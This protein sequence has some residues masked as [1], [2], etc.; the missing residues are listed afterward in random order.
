MK[1][2]LIF[3]TAL[4]ALIM[5]TRPALALGDREAAILG[6]V[7]GGA[8]I[9]AAIDD[10]FDHRHHRYD[11]HRDGRNDRGY[12]YDRH[13]RRD[14]GRDRHADRRYDRDRRGHDRGGY[15]VWERTRVWVPKRV[16]WT[17]DRYGR[18]VKHFQRGH[19]E[20][21]RRKVWVRDRGRRW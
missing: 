8:I 5:T 4:A 11:R 13:D 6:G 20:Y 16:Y 9:A 1:K 10:N 3:A 21:Q 2:T 17:T 15:Y 14:R 19:W 7:L 18:S 12:R